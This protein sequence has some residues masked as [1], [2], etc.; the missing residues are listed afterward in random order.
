VVS[1][2]ITVNFLNVEILSCLTDSLPVKFAAK[3]GVEIFDFYSMCLI[4]SDPFETKLNSEEF[5]GKNIVSTIFLF[6]NASVFILIKIRFGQ[7]VIFNILY[8]KQLKI[9]NIEGRQSL[10]SLLKCANKVLSSPP[11]P[12]TRRVITN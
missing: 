11:L 6:L 2:S 1:V 7:N 4:Q 3:L 12:V 5:Y 9:S 10:L 8:A